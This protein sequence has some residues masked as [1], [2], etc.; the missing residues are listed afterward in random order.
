MRRG[1]ANRLIHGAFCTCI[2]GG[3]MGGWM[4]WNGQQLSR[5][6]RLPCFEA[7]CVEGD[8]MYAYASALDVTV[9]T[10]RPNN[11]RNRYQRQRAQLPQVRAPP[12]YQP[13]RQVLRLQR[14]MH[15]P[16]LYYYPSRPNVLLEHIPLSDPRHPLWT[17]DPPPTRRHS[18]AASPYPEHQL[19]RRRQR[20]RSE[21][22]RERALELAMEVDPVRELRDAQWARRQRTSSV[23]AVSESV[24]Q[25]RRRRGRA[26]R[27]PE[28]GSVRGVGTGASSED[29]AAFWRGTPSSVDLGPRPAATPEIALSTPR[30]TLTLHHGPH[31]PAS[32]TSPSSSITTTEPLPQRLRRARS[33]F[34]LRSRRTLSSLHQRFSLRQTRSKLRD[35][36]STFSLRVSGRRHTL[37]TARAAAT[38]RLQR[39]RGVLLERWAP[40]RV[41][42]SSASVL[43]RGP[44]RERESGEGLGRRLSRQLSR[45]G[46]GNPIPPALRRGRGQERGSERGRGR[47]GDGYDTDVQHVE[48]ALEGLDFGGGISF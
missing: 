39:V 15:S 37:S 19:G 46:F 44:G 23:S 3:R 8:E 17:G 48:N 24:V 32:S 40:G 30:E 25:E 9:D 29:D 16:P 41:P 6:N 31:E 20:S 43:E 27:W 21:V 47:E 35:R 14:S 11:F 13:Q 38:G 45:W 2:S 18:V 36:R 22:A 4:Q 42:A 34:S 7:Y 12:Q 33:T 5:C 1:K 28:S 26:T 10:P